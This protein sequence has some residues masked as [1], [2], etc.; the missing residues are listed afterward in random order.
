MTGSA[1][2]GR[3]QVSLARAISKFGIASRREAEQLIRDGKVCV[4][5]RMVRDPRRWLNPRRDAITLEGVPLRKQAAVYL[6]MHKPAGF[7]T[8]RSDERGRKTVYDLLPPG[9]ARVFPIGR[10]DK[11]TSGLLLFT[12]DTRFGEKVTNPLR[13]LPKAYRVELESPLSAV[14]RLSM[15]RGM[16]LADGTRLKP[17]RVHP[18]AANPAV[19]LITVV[20]GKNRQIRRM[21]EELGHKVRALRRLSIGPVLLGSL[22]EGATRALSGPERDSIAGSQRR[23]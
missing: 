5:G 7:V 20:E 16:V 12:N 4:N 17:A 21:C 3:E 2:Q 1:R 6:A 23:S 10:L 19:V 8:T 13:M 15:E 9:T 22:A 11:D 18:E 14:E